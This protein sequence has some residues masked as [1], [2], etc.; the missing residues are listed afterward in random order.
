MLS[1]LLNSGLWLNTYHSTLIRMRCLIQKPKAFTL[2]ILSYN[3]LKTLALA[4]AFK[5]RPFPN[6]CS[7]AA[8]ERYCVQDGCYGLLKATWLVLV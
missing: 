4:V 1:T 8:F 6:F 5:I 7:F 3:G 2:F